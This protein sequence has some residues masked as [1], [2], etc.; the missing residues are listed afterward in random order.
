MSAEVHNAAEPR[1]GNKYHLT[2][3]RQM[4]MRAN[5]VRTPDLPLVVAVTMTAATPGIQPITN[6]NGN[7]NSNGSQPSVLRI[8]GIWNVQVR[9]KI[10]NR[11]LATGWSR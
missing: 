8:N 7:G 4:R 3:T 11:N 2:P 5:S 10:R 1:I 6:N 9:A